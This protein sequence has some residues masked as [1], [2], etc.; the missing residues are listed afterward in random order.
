[1]IMCMLAYPLEDNHAE[2]CWVGNKFAVI[3]MIWKV[4]INLK[5]SK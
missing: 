2:G 5:Y 1:M 4:S 3:L